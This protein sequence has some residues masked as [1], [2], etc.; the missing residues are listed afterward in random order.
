MHLFHRSLYDVGDLWARNQVSVAVEHLAT[1]ITEYLIQSLYPIIFSGDRRELKAVVACV[2]NEYHQIGGK[3]VADMLELRGWNSWFLGANT[4]VDDL[5]A[6]LRDKS[7][8]LLALSLSVYM[9]RSRL[10][11]TIEKVRNVF[12]AL[13][14][15][16]GGQAFCHGGRDIQR[17]YDNVRYISGLEELDGYALE[18]EQK[19][20]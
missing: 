19:H 10:C 18:L 3:M 7:P 4:P 9:N 20:G 17:Q 5:L 15:I 12:P 2:A 11:D 1:A 8:H 6:L 13:P 14:I 16:V